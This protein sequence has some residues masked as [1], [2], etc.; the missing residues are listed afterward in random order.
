MS[1]KDGHPLMSDKHLV[2][3]G[4]GLAGLSAGCYARR[5]G[6][7]TTIIEHNLA[8]GGVCT[9]WYPN[10]MAVLPMT[11]P[12]SRLADIATTPTRTAPGQQPYGH[13]AFLWH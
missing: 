9:A 12:T 1:R 3:V 4:C 5:N 8:L 6:F 13:L 11:D 10:V 2:I 7:R